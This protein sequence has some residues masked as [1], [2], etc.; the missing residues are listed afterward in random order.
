MTIDEQ[1]ASVAVIGLGK[2][3][4]TLAAVFATNGYYIF[5]ADKNKEVVASINQGKS[6]INNEPGLD[7]L[8]SDAVE[9]NQMRATSDNVEAV[10]HSSIIV[11]IV[12]VLVDT[13]NQIDYQMI[14]A[15]VE[16]IAKGIKK[17][18]LVIFETTL[19]PG[20]T[21]NRFGKRIEERSG[22][23]LGTDFYLAYSPERVYSNRIIEDL[24]K[25][26]K[27]VGGINEKSLL[28][29]STF[30]KQA[31]N[32]QLIEV[33]SI[34]TAEFSK[35][36]ECVYR[37]VNIALANELAQFADQ[38][39]VNISEV[40]VASNSQPYSH[41]HSPGIGVGGHC[42]P[43]YPYFFINKGLNQGLTPLAREV[44]DGMAA[45]AI[46]QVKKEVGSLANRNVLILGLSYRENVKEPT[47]STTLLLIDQLLNMN[48]N[49]FVND[50]LFS[51]REIHAFGVTPLSLQDK[52]ISKIDI[53][54]LQAYHD[55]Y[56]NLNFKDFT[57]CKLL[58]D[59]RNQLKQEDIKKHGI[60][61]QSIGQQ[62]E[63]G[64]W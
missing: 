2:I 20:D 35:V 63:K 13:A 57:N 3:G 33:S 11:V 36:A 55:D 10:A 28:L 5:G 50:P 4:L 17:G 22:L 59:G 60:T 34:E 31:L 51:D 19:P 24:E 44:N 12:P 29:A 41:I 61:Y 54:I 14:D 53:I 9:N 23:R 21:K 25:Y 8:V 15:V 43:I 46:S 26:P 47:K 16:D 58:F 40:I 64:E 27:V 1:Q 18:S 39:G 42:I 48:A 6:H 32:C 62:S 56:K 38:T 49:V 52:S 30:Y 7:Q 45:Y 37:D